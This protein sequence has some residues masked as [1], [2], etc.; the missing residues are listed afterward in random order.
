M[1]IQFTWRSFWKG[2]DIFVNLFPGMVMKVFNEEE[3]EDFS[4]KLEQGEI[5]KRI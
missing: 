5:H 1:L 4:G 2:Q 3:W